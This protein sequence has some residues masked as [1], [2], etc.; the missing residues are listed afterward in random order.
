MGVRRHPEHGVNATIPTCFF[1]GGEKNELI[2]LGA[3]SKRITGQDK[4]PMKG[5]VFDT[6][7]CDECKRLMGL[8]VILVSVKD[9]DEGKENPYRTGGFSVVTEDFIKRVVT[10]EALQ[11]HLLRVRFCYVPDTVYNALGLNQTKPEG[12]QNEAT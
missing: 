7:P 10:P 9:E 1:C 4:A 2:L 11:N 8:G 12:K 6:V 3:N 5:P